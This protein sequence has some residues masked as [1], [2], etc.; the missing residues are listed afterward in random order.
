M[1]QKRITG[2]S[3][4]VEKERS[5]WAEDPQDFNGPASAPFEERVTRGVIGIA[6]IIETKII[7]WRSDHEIYTFALKFSHPCQAVT[8]MK[9]E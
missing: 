6:A 4:Q 1:R 8:V 3:A 9:L 5:S 7:R 2:G